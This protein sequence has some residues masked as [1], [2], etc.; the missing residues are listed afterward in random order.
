MMLQK[1]RRREA[2]TDYRKRMRLLKGGS[3]RIVFRKT[4]M[5]II[6]QLVESKE[7]RDSVIVGVNSKELFRFGWP[8]KWAG[9]LKSMP[10]AYL[11]GFLLAKKIKDKQLGTDFIFDIGLAR[12]VKASRAYAFAKGIIDNSIKL[13]CKKEILP[14]D[15]RVKGMHIKKDILAVFEDI[16]KKIEEG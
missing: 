15:D 3:M 8:E 11:T 10:A 1:R 13:R 12:S 14:S 6:C 16:I 2:K 9:S 5:Y 4:N 7:A